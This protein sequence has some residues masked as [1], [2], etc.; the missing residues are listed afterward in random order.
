MVGVVE[1]IVLDRT[2]TGCSIYQERSGGMELQEGLT[3]HRSHHFQGGILD[4]GSV[5][6]SFLAAIY[7]TALL[8]IQARYPELLPQLISINFYPNMLHQF[9]SSFSIFEPELIYSIQT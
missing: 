5:S 8:S 1:R 9:R 2:F 4:L 6:N 3:T 7:R